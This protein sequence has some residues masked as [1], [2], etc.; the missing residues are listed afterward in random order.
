MSKGLKIILVVLGVYA[1]ITFAHLWLNVGFEH[2]GLTGTAK[3]DSF[4]VGFLPVT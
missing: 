3:A 1:G 2:L 4:R